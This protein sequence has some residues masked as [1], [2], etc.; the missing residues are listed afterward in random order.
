MYLPYSSE[1]P[2]T[3]P[4]SGI[5]APYSVAMSTCNT[6]PQVINNTMVPGSVCCPGQSPRPPAGSR[7]QVSS[8]AP[9]STPLMQQQQMYSSQQSRSL[10]NSSVYS[11]S[12]YGNQQYTQP[13][14]AFRPSP[15]TMN[16]Q[17]TASVVT[18]S[19]TPRDAQGNNCLTMHH[20][21][22]Q[23][24]S[25]QLSVSQCSNPS[26]I[27]GPGSLQSGVRSIGSCSVN[28]GTTSIYNHPCTPTGHSVPS[29]IGSNQTVAPN[30]STPPCVMPTGNS[31]VMGSHV[32]FAN[33]K[34][35]GSNDI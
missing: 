31:R 22:P 18:R 23:Q 6:I 24:Q 11:G 32:S 10:N 8:N 21:L 25:Q 3:Q 28:S 19:T 4:G 35:I 33:L 29:A 14:P 7:N 20:T 16:S 26:P 17:T 5:T 13:S 9:T 34:N 2:V 15:S 27:V 30:P 1:C 12:C